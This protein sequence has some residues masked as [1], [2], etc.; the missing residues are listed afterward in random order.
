MEVRNIEVSF[1]FFLKIF[2]FLVFLVFLWEI[3]EVILIFLTSVIF[4]AGIEVWARYLASKIKISYFLAVISIFIFLFFVVSLVFYLLIPIA[5]NELKS[6]IPTIVNLKNSNLINYPFVREFIENFQEQVSFYL[7]NISKVTLKLLG[8]LAN[9]ILI[10]A[11]AFYLALQGKNFFQNI[12]SIFLPTYWVRRFMVVWE[13]SQLK[14]AQW[15]SGELILMLIVGILTFIGL[16]VIGVPYAALL[17]ILGG[18]LEIVPFIGPVM[19]AIIAGIIS[20]SKNLYTAVLAIVV[21]G[22]IQQLENHVIV[23]NVMKSKVQLNP[24]LVI[25]SLIIGGK[26]AGLIGILISVPFMSAVIEVI[27]FLKEQNFSLKDILKEEGE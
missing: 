11:I 4:A 3:R 10:I 17:G 20:L 19:T 13:I 26:I 21:I 8:G 25:L 27:K 16:S 14:F 5:L 24:V 12:L 7:A 18:L 22:F 15:L 23:P 9:L 6:A 1:K 2:L